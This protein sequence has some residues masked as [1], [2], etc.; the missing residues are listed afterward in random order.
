[1]PVV[2]SGGNSLQMA[3][4]FSHSLMLSSTAFGSTTSTQFQTQNGGL[5][6]TFTGSG[7]SGGAIPTNGT[8][9]GI[10]ISGGAS[11]TGISY[12]VATLRA[13][14]EV[15]VM[16]A[17]IFASNDTVNGGAFS[18]ALTGFGG[19]NVLNG[20][21]G[22]DLLQTLG[23]GDT[24]DGGSGI[25]VVYIERTSG[26]AVTLNL[27]GM[28]TSG[29]ILLNDGTSLRN[30]EAFNVTTGAGADVLTFTGPISGSN[31]FNAG[32]GVDR[33]VL[34]LTGSTNNWRQQLDRVVDQFGSNV[35]IMS[36]VEIYQITGGLGDDELQGGANNDILNGSD[37]NDLIRTGGGVDTVDGGVGIDRVELDLSA[38]SAAVTLDTANLGTNTGVTFANGTFVRNIET[39]YITLGAGNDTITASVL[40][41]AGNTSVFDAGAGFDALT[42]D[43]SASNVSLGSRFHYINFEQVHLLAG[44][45][46]D[47]VIG[48]SG[49]DVLHGGG[50]DDIIYGRGGIDTLDGG[51][52]LDQIVFNVSSVTDNLTV[53]LGDFATAQ[54][55]TFSNGTVVRNAER[56]AMTSGSGND[57][58][59][60]TTSVTGYNGFDGGAGFDTVIFDASG[61]SARLEFNG[62][63][64]MIYNNAYIILQSVDRFI[65]TGGSGEDRL[66]ALD[67]TVG[68]DIFNG[69]DN[70][71]AMDG[72][73]G[74][75]IMNGDGGDD[76]IV[77]RSGADQIN[78][79]TGRDRLVVRLDPDQINVS[80]T[81]NVSAFSGMSSSTGVTLASGATI[82]SMETMQA[83]LS[84]ADDT[85]VVNSQVIEE[86]WVIGELG[87]DTLQ[88]NLAHETQSIL[89]S[90][91]TVA[92][93]NSY[94]RLGFN[95]QPITFTLSSVERLVANLGTAHDSATGGDNNDIINGGGGNDYIQGGFGSDVI[96]GGDG[97]DGLHGYGNAGNNNGSVSDAPDTLRGGAGDDFLYGGSG[98]DILDGGDG[99]DTIGYNTATSAVVANLATPSS[100]TGEAAGDVF[101]S[102]EGIVG[103]DS[104]GDTL[105]GHDGDNRLLGLGGADT[106]NGGAGEDVLEGGT[107]DDILSGGSGVDM[108]SYEFETVGVIVSLMAQGAAQNTG[109]GFDTLTGI[110]NLLGSA[111]NDSLTG[112]GGGNF[113]FGMAGSDTLSGLGGADILSGEAGDD[114]L[115]ADSTDTLVSGGAGT[116]WVYFLD[117]GNANLDAGANGVEVVLAG[118]GSDTINAATQTA[119]FYTYAGGGNDTV[120]GGSNNDH[121]YG[122]DG[123]DVIVGGAGA[124]L[125]WGEAGADSLSGGDGSDTL[126]T[127]NLDTLVSGGAGYDYVYF[128]GAGNFVIDAGAAGLEWL[129]AAGG[130]DAIN[131]ASQSAGVVVYGA[132]GSDVITGGAG[133]DILFGQEGND[134]IV[135]GAQNDTLW[136]EAGADSLSGGDGDDTLI[137]DVADALISGGAG[138]DYIYLTGAGNFVIDAA[139]AGIE[140]ILSLDGNDALNAASASASFVAYAGGGDDAVTGGNGNDSFFGQDGNDVLIGGAGGDVLLGEAGTDTITGG[141]GGD[142]IIGGLGADTFVYQAG[143]GADSVLDFQNGSDLFDM[144]ALAANGVN[145]ISDLIIGSNGADATIFWNG[146]LIVVANAAGQIDS[147]DFIFGP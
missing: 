51:D 94:G 68:N 37:G 129:F 114:F 66:Y 70:R 3:D 141:A 87:L 9:T 54:G 111:H 34:D 85:I 146:D 49:N 79:G 18:D 58:L 25:D 10:S 33:I 81:F 97:D 63:G 144:T 116:D 57:T 2:S 125:I 139:T 138:T 21:D 108:A 140:W 15:G 101:T 134:T 19:T 5:I 89:V 145:D 72:Y 56:I 64:N 17:A 4:P 122:Q 48:G 124:D 53:R 59:E 36:G 91:A 102:I 118:G 73:Y 75:D 26:A 84:N 137:V 99:F 39:F 8:I 14:P 13:G 30:L 90:M 71:D 32:G 119:I 120:T 61:G 20:G 95:D 127:D 88:L 77:Y 106:L 46:N 86:V 104:Y 100:N 96:E 27:T 76:D 69:G 82:R 6:W 133:A 74:D 43:F 62:L 110:E 105:T 52:G 22:D 93:M 123:N 7:F 121:L 29:G 44:S 28:N 23:T 107:G 109:A 12:S 24:L 47:E 78:G 31:L 16:L 65:L 142:V 42:A 60:L 98:G 38:S 112:D 132:G 1:M 147:S 80:Q 92:V 126:I 40:P 113:L 117:N 136:G 115:F 143:W 128:I 83:E 41:G 50:G 131:A 55:V 45:A 130:D 103:S 11:V 35:L 135:G 67:T